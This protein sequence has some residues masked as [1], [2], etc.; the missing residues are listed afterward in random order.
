MIKYFSAGT[1]N[2]SLG[3]YF[4]ASTKSKHPYKIKKRGKY[5]NL[6]LIVKTKKIKYPRD[7][8]KL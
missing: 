5:F 8:S 3:Y 2:E 4:F 6:P 1:K 7:E